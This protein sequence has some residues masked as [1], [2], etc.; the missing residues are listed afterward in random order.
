MSIESYSQTESN[1]SKDQ[2]N[3]FTQALNWFIVLLNTKDE[4]KEYIPLIQKHIS[5]FQDDD[6]LE[7]ENI[8]IKMDNIEKELISKT[9]YYYGEI[10]SHYYECCYNAADLLDTSDLI[11]KIPEN[12]GISYNDEN[13][14]KYINM[15]IKLPKLVN[16][17]T[18]IQPIE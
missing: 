5:L 17:T 13:D 4:Y 12:Q 7:I 11:H 9:F 18:N 2:E 15:V 6:Q 14:K 10:L 1:K 16:Q 3:C 8:I